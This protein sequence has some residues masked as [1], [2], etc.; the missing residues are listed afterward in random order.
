[1]PAL[2]L[3]SKAQYSD[4]DEQRAIKR[5]MFMAWNLALPVPVEYGG[6]IVADVGW[7]RKTNRVWAAAPATYDGLI[8]LA[9]AATPKMHTIWMSKYDFNNNTLGNNWIDMWSLK[10]DP[11][12]GTYPGAAST[13]YVHAAI[14]PGVPYVGPPLVGGETTRSVVGIEIQGINNGGAAPMA[15]LVYDR[16]M[17][18]CNSP[19]FAG[20]TT[21]TNTVTPTRGGLGL[22]VQPIITTQTAFGTSVN[23]TNYTYKAYGGATGRSLT[24]PGTNGNMFGTTTASATVPAT[25]NPGSL[26]ATGWT[27]FLPLLAGDSGIISLTSYT[28]DVTTTGAICWV[29]AKPIVIMSNRVGQRAYIQDLLTQHPVLHS[30]P[31]DACLSFL[32]A[33]FNDA[34]TSASTTGLGLVTLRG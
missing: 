15:F 9:T 24:V 2:A 6:K 1:M 13:A 23:L 34:S 25:C 31:D 3:R 21:M 28:T 22:G 10:G 27:P 19:L 18:Y 26:S 30:V 32:T 17:V 29:L 33:S 7:D 8:A 11:Q 20:T 12:G 14:D 5:A 16:I 4:C